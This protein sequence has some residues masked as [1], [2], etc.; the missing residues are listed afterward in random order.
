MIFIDTFP[1]GIFG[2]FSGVAE[3]RP[4]PLIHIARLLRWREYSE[5][6]AKASHSFRHDILVEDLDGEHRESLRR[7]SNA[8]ESLRLTDPPE[9]PTPALDQSVHRLS[10]APRP[11]LIVHSGSDDELGELIAYAMEMQAVEQVTAS[12]FLLSPGRPSRL[13]REIVYLDFYPACALFPYSDR[14]ITGCGFNVM[15]QTEPFR[16]KHR[17]IPF[18]R[19]WDDQFSRA[20]RRRERRNGK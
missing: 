1:A 7:H 18:A 4:I 8:L 17:F 11:W 3:L 14:I 6:R 15:R 16:E 9:P 20:A 19:R 12:V 2:E 13:P 10:A 5:R